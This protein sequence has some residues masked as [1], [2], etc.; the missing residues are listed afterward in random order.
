MT[1]TRETMKRPQNICT[2]VVRTTLAGFYISVLQGKRRNPPSFAFPP[3]STQLDLR[4]L[5][6]LA[7]STEHLAWLPA[8]HSSLVTFPCSNMQF[9]LSVT[10]RCKE[11]LWH[12]ECSIP[13]QPSML[14]WA[15]QQLA[16]LLAGT[17][18]VQRVPSKKKE[19]SSGL[20]KPPPVTTN[21]ML[22][23]I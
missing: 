3:Q 10:S 19:L 2:K 15:P 13:Q 21:T 22:F 16:A 18:H 14:S 4:R 1:Q 20:C 6:F 23:T 8:F 12:K 11:H 17:A 5:P 9:P 7:L